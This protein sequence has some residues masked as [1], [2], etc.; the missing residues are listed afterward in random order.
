M[1]PLFDIHVHLVPGVDDGAADMDMALTMI[2]M[3]MAQGVSAIVATPHNSAY[4]TDPEGTAQ[5]AQRLYR[6]AKQRFPEL[7]LLFGCEIYCDAHGMDTVLQALKTGRYPT[8]NHTDYV[9]MEFSPWTDAAEVISCVRAAIEAGWK[10]VIAHMERYLYLI[11][12]MQTVDALRQ[13]GC[14]IQTNAYSYACETNEEIKGWARR[15]ALEKKVDLL[16]TDS[17]RT[18]HRPPIVAEGVAWICEH[19]DQSYGD[20]I[21]WHN[22]QRL[23]NT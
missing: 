9:L 15:L 4:D 3:A 1:K 5:Q 2:Q 16:G 19:C 21:T 23:L 17:H 18:T 6:Q 7:T 14:L 8:L 11:G 20:A 12:D 22:G 10:P 13:M